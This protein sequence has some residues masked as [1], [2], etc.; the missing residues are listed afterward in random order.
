MKTK[1]LIVA[2]ALMFAVGVRA[3]STAHVASAS[4]SL[5]IQGEVSAITGGN[6]SSAIS[7]AVIT[8]PVVSSFLL[9]NDT[10]T[11][12]GLV[13]DLPG[14]EFA[15]SQL[16]ALQKLIS[17][18]NF[19]DLQFY[20]AG[21]TGYAQLTDA[22]GVT[23]KHVAYTFGGGANYDPTSSGHFTINLFDVRLANF[24]QGK[25][26]LFTSGIGWHFNF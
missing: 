7:D 24:G 11:Q 26:I 22:L 25:R 15:F 20:A 17:K 19:K 8:Y 4:N 23:S 18:T 6:A 9:R 21:S 3:Q 5:T 13:A 14:A 10:Y 2:F 12:P 1:L 16:P